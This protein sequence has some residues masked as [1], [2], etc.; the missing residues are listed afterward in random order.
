MRHDTNSASKG[1]PSLTSTYNPAHHRFALLLAGSTLVLLV[2]G[3]LVTS[4][5]AGLAV[6]DWPTSF[7]SIYKIPPMVGG[8]RFEHSH[9]M[10]AEFIGV[11]T[12]LMA[13]WTW[14]A[15][16]R[17]WMRRLALGALA[18]VIFQG[19][20]GGTTVL[21]YLPPA[22]SS[23]H[24][25]FA[26]TF[27]CVAVLM[28]L[29]TSPSWVATER[30][31]LHDEGTPSLRT[32][33]VVLIVALYAQLILGAAFRHVWTKLG[34]TGANRIAASEIVGT[35]L[36]P[37]VLNALLVTALL[38]WVATRVL[39][40]YGKV[41]TLRKPAAALLFLVAAQLM[42]GFGAYLA[43]IEWGRDAAQPHPFMVWSTVAH[44]V[45]GAA[46]LAT[47]VVLTAQVYRN[48][49][50]QEQEQLATEAGKA[51]AV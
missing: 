19:L 38:I 48:L 2:A 50:S 35:Y 21:N 23:A 3:A 11:L 15:E 22:V 43:R 39:A 13:V 32:L 5:D 12:I 8:V 33:T 26:Q 24:A 31:A 25:T 42:L 46:V 6:P 34:P 27:F 1:A 41:P 10:V 47:S 49:L 51:A 20:L 37:H 7:G 17:R 30:L 4:N 14:R 16:P 9:R 40:R 28:A 44:V 18:L 36:V 29:F 45:T